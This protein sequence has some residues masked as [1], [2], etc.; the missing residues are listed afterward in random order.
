MLRA[1]KAELDPTGC[2]TPA[3]SSPEAVTSAKDQTSELAV[4]FRARRDRPPSS[5]GESRRRRR[6]ASDARSGRASSQRRRSRRRRAAARRRAARP[7]GRWPGRRDAASRAPAMPIG[8]ARRRPPRRPALADAGRR[9]PRRTPARG[10]AR[11]A[12]ARPAGTGAP[13][14]V[15]D[16]GVHDAAAG[17]EPLHRAGPDD[18]REP[19]RGVPQ[20]ALEHPGDDLEIG[21]RMVGI[22]VPGGSC[23]SLWRD[24]RVEP[25]IC[26]VV[27]RPERE[28]VPRHAPRRGSRTTSP[29][30]RTAVTAMPISS[31]M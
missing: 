15:G 26:W 19:R 6:A 10:P 16:L 30:R 5:T 29:N 1:L 20:R 22:P 28:R 24:E 11:R 8:E 13:R 2:S 31:R 25:D 7:T 27:V 12:R 23:S 9:S 21:M 4:G 18:V 14:P 3:C 17:G